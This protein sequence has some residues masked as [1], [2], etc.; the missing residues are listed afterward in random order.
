MWNPWYGEVKAEAIG[1]LLNLFHLNHHGFCNVGDG[2]QTNKKP[3]STKC[4]PSVSGVYA[5]YLN[6]EA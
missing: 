5:F 6:Y 1:M 2:L 4:K 3:V